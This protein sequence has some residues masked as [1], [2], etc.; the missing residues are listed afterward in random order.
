MVNSGVF[1]YWSKC[2]YRYSTVSLVQGGAQH[3]IAFPC[4]LN[5][6]LNRYIVYATDLF[7]TFLIWQVVETLVF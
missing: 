2:L 4:I 1:V 6:H 7:L 5:L 3:V